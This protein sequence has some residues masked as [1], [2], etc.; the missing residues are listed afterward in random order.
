VEGLAAV[1]LER[2]GV[3]AGWGPERA[4]LPGA[5]CSVTPI[6]SWLG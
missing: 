1:S 6:D 4:V 3:A 2:A 5:R